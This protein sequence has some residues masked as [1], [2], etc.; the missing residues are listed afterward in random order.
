[1]VLHK[2]VDG[3]DT[4]FSTIAGPLANNPLSKWLGVIIR[5]IYQAASEDSRWAYELVSDLWPYIDP[6]IYS[7]NDGSIYRGRKDQGNPYNKEQ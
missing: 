2:N 5:G 1:M 6:S 4:R 3:A 7:R